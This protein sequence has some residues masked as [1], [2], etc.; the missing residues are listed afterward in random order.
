MVK[1]RIKWRT[2]TSTRAFSTLLRGMQSIIEAKGVDGFRTLRGPE[3][4]SD[5][6]LLSDGAILA[7]FF[8]ASLS[9]SR[10]KSEQFC[11]QAAYLICMTHAPLCDLSCAFILDGAGIAFPMGSR[12]ITR[13]N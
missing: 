4:P 6:P 2:A 13:S 9:P 5:F 10:V 3:R 1:G 11:K 7:L 12:S 8:T